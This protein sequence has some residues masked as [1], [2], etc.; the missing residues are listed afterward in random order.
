MFDDDSV[1]LEIGEN[2]PMNSPALAEARRGGGGNHPMTSPALGDARGSADT[3]A[4]R[5]EH[6][7]MA[8]LA[9]GEVRGSV[10]RL[11][12]K[13]HPVPTPA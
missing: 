5:G 12:T 10:R 1:S 9:L 11:L 4:F 8:S 13:N 6:H 3:P 7:P 2:H